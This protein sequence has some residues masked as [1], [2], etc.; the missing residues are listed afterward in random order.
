[1]RNPFEPVWLNFAFYEFF[2]SA[3]VHY[4]I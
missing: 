2:V 3:I 4:P 1:M